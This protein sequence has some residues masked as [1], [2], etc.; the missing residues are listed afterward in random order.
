MLLLKRC[1]EMY[2][3]LTI[4][5]LKCRDIELE[6]QRL[7]VLF[8][9]NHTIWYLL[10]RVEMI[11]KI[12]KLLVPSLII[13]FLD[14]YLNTRHANNWWW[15]WCGGAVRQ[16]QIIQWLLNI[17]VSRPIFKMM[18]GIS[19]VISTLRSNR[20]HVVVINIHIFVVTLLGGFK[21]LSPT[22][23]HEYNFY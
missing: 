19:W 18:I 11:S 2:D 9:I 22:D 10:I 1:L 23:L 16:Q 15:C 5:R 12:L 20:K 6:Y 21:L 17:Y 4:F 3:I 7:S 14:N 8:H 13:H